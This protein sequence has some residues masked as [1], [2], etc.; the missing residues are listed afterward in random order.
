MDSDPQNNFMRWNICSG[1]NQG[2]GHDEACSIVFKYGMKRDFNKWLA[3]L[4]PSAPVKTLT[5]LRQWNLAHQKLGAIRYGQALLDISDEMDV[6]KDRARYEA[7]RAK[8]LRLAGTHGLDEALQNNKL[9]AL[10]FPGANLNGIAAKTGYPV[11]VV[12]L[13]LVPNSPNNAPFPPGF[14]AKPGPSES[15]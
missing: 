2:K 10:M 9:D 6:E 13:G 4:G 1:A 5:E 12:P 7:D 8:D 15:V 14:D 3:S 11:V